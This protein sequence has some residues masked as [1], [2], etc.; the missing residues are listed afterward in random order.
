MTNV[1]FTEKAYCKMVLHAAKYPHCSVNGVLLSKTSPLNNNKEIEFVDV[2]PLFHVCLNL[3]PMAEIALMQIDEYASRRG[4][5]IAGYYVAPENIRDDSF[6]KLYNRI[7]DKIAA[8]CNSS[9]VVIVNTTSTSIQKG[10]RALKVAHY[11]D[12]SYKQCEDLSISDDAI[13]ICISGLNECLYN[14]LV[15]FDNHLDDIT[16]DWTNCTLNKEIQ[17]L[18]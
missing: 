9:Y 7:S 10:R 6:D 12:G 4:L 14:K 17:A 2:I 15:D 13:N 18:L 5:T 16:Q 3:T 1:K 8:N 11:T